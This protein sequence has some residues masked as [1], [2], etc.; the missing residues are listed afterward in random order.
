MSD[1]CFICNESLSSGDVVEVRRGLQTLKNASVAR[2]DGN[3]EYLNT[4]TVVN[5]HSNCRKNYTNNLSIAAFKRRQ[6]E[7]ST[8]TSPRKKRINSFDFKKLCLFC[9]EEASEELERKKE[10]KYRHAIRKVSTLTFKDTVLKAAE[11]RGDKYGRNVKER[12]NFQYDLVS[13]EAKYHDKCFS[14]FLLLSGKGDV[15]RPLDEN[16]RIAMDNVFHYIENNDD[17][18][19]TLAELKDVIQG[20]VP[21]DKT[22]IKKLIA[23]YGSNIV[24]TTKSKSLTII[25]FRDTADNILTNSWYEERKT[26]FCDERSRIV[27]AAASIIKEDIRSITI[28]HDSYPP[29]TQMLDKINDDI[30][31]TLSHF[32]HELIVKNKKGPTKKVEAKST[33]IAHAIMSVMRPRS[34]SSQLLLSLSV[35]LHRRYASKRLLC[36]CFV[37]FWILC[38]IQ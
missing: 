5:V 9:G 34:F 13:V 30:P 3:I 31:Q 10:T 16:I 17:C 32:L 29:P 4:V 24:I 14:N 2:S 38:Y 35:F 28:I 25:C 1:K 12:V 6:E 11:A 26:N 20:Y 23:R 19:F 8:S 27:E 36:R 37:K 22:I 7:P 15:G 33:A 21:D 18:Q